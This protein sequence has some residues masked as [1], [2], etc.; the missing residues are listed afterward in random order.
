MYIHVFVHSYIVDPV[1]KRVRDISAQLDSLLAILESYFFL[2]F[3][4]FY[5]IKIIWYE[6]AD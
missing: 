6:F 4:Y 5:V 3:F 1:Y 2:L